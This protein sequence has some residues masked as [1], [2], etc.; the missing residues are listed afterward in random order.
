M[1]DVPDGKKYWL[2]DPR[3]VDKIYYTLVTLCAILLLADFLY[4]K[5]G[6]FAWEDWFGFHALFGFTVFVLIVLAGK[7]LRKVVMRD[8]DYY[9]R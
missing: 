3:N 1:K 9:D 7:Q 2:D 5:H 8:E 6:H 4:T